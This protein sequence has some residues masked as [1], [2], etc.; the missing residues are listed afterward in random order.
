MNRDY[1]W[2]WGHV[3]QS[4]RA[5]RYVALLNRLRPDDEPAN[6]PNT[7]TWI[8]AQ[9]GERILEIGCGNGAVA[10]AVTRAVPDIRELVAVDASAEMIAEAQRRAEVDSPVSFQV[11]D[12]HHLPFPDASFDRCYAMETFVILPD[13]Y[14]AIKE[15]VRVTRPGG[16]LCLWESDCDAR[17]MLASDLAVSRRLMRFVGEQEFNG[18][19]ARQLIGWL[20]E[21]GWQVDI[22]PSVPISN[23][24]AFLTSWLLDEWLADA[25]EAGVVTPE[26]AE[27]FLMEMRQR[28]ETNLFLSYTVNFRITARKP[29]AERG[30][31]NSDNR[32]DRSS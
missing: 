6:F 11:A 27:G 13:P 20:K 15:L 24:S 23:G 31:A 8:D 5:S 17:A 2:R 4:E 29:V 30:L 9:P 14:Q 28:Q 16:Y 22:V 3:D 25:V 21:L 7:L 19:V 18:A 1:K 12:A 32:R 10:R 26:E